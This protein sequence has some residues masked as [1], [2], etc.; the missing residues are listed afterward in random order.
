MKKI[1][2]CGTL[3]LA[4][5]AGT[6][7]FA[8][9]VTYVTTDNSVKIN[10]ADGY[11]TVLVYSS[12]DDLTAEKIVYVNQA[13]DGKSFSQAAQFLLKADPQNGKYTIRLGGGKT[14]S[15][16]SKDFY[17]GVG[18][19]TES[20]IKM[21]PITA[22]GGFVKREDD[23]WSIGYTVSVSEG[24]YR[25]ILVQNGDKVMGYSIDPLTVS[26]QGGVNIGVQLDGVSEAEK[27]AIEVYLSKGTVDPEKGEVR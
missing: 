23:N 24:T 27:D 1:I 4:L 13:E 25:A 16:F 19:N 2:A 11:R 3:L 21:E 17:I 18:S 20:N 26:G 14:L 8:E 7:S 22:E 15:T 12:D 10:N 6:V 5:A 9:D